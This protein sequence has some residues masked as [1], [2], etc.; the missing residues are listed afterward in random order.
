[1]CFFR[2]SD[3]LKIANILTFIPAGHVYTSATFL[4]TVVQVNPPNAHLEYIILT[5]AALVRSQQT[6]PNNINTPITI[7]NNLI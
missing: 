6:I 2:N 5:L 3:N 7:F 4:P 1:M